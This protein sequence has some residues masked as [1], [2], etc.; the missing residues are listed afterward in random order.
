[1][2][3][4]IVQRNFFELVTDKKG[5]SENEMHEYVNLMITYF[6]QH[7]Y[8]YANKGMLYYNTLNDKEA[9]KYYLKAHQIDKTDAIVWHSLAATYVNLKKYNK[10]KK[11]YKKLIKHSNNDAE[12]LEYKRQLKKIKYFKKTKIN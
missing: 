6:P 2:M 9:L 1:M 10:A 12:I 4:K 8:G 3:L 5:W 7:T 11:L